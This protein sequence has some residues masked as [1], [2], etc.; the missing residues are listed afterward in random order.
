M[1]LTALAMAARFEHR[2]ISERQAEKFTILR[3]QGRPRGRAAVP[4]GG[5]RPDH[6][7]AR[8][9]LSLRAIVDV[10]VSEASRPPRAGRG[11]Q[12]ASGPRSSPG[13]ASC[14]RWRAERARAGLDRLARPLGRLRQHP[15]R[16][17]ARDVSVA[18]LGVRRNRLPG[19]VRTQPLRVHE[20]DATADHPGKGNPEIEPLTKED[21]R[22]IHAQQL[23]QQANKRVQADVQAKQ[24][25][26]AD[27]RARAR[28]APAAL[29]DQCPKSA[30]RETSAGTLAGGVVDWPILR[31]DPAPTARRSARRT[32]PG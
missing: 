24:G 17:E 20:C 23:E 10:L 2:R 5:G 21:R 31:G 15:R 19:R 27:P 4:R 29:P 18:Q 3:K 22:G 11:P 16:R 9:G 12:R 26:R 7:H 13:S 28:A 8:G 25:R 6:R 14:R 1:V 32:A 30:H